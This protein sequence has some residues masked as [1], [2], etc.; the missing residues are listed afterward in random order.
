MGSLFIFFVSSLLFIFGT[1]VFTKLLRRNP[2][3]RYLH[4]SSRGAVK[5]AHYYKLLCLGLLMLV[6]LIGILESFSLPF[7]GPNDASLF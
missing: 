3:F 6:W 1:K 4:P 2:S 5:V 7:F